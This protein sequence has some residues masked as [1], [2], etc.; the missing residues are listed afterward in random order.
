MKILLEPTAMLVAYT[1]EPE[2]LIEKMGRLCYKSEDKITETSHVAFI[3]ML[4]D[5]TRQHESVLEHASASFILGTD[6]GISHELVR[7]RLA[8]YSQ[9]S[10]RYCNYSKE[11]FGGEI[12]VVKPVDLPDNC[13]SYR[14]WEESM[15]E[16]EASYLG[17]LSRS[18]SPQTARSVLPTCLYTE[19][20]MTANFREWRHFLKLRTS[21]AAHPDM[22]VLALKI[23]SRLRFIAPTVFGD[24]DEA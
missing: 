3:R 20:G 10:T 1:H 13:G 2:R 5:L 9:T 23:Q 17:L 8:S 21:P 18:I 4:L 16:A 14:I 6:R 22:R 12:T 7:H 15:K 24:P 19:V 11:K